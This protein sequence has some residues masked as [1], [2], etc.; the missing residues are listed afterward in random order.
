MDIINN[1]ALRECVPECQGTWIECVKEVLQIKNVPVAEFGGAVCDLFTTGRGKNRNIF[2]C[3]PAN[4]GKTFFL[5]LLHTL[6][7]TFCSPANH[8]FAWAA[9]AQAD[10]F[11]NKF[12]WH[13]ELIHWE[14]VLLLLKGE[15]VYFPTPKSISRRMCASQEI[16]QCLRQESLSLLSR[17][18][19]THLT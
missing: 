12:R 13:I 2:I 10:V 3:S 1:N 6:S 8:R 7:K 17:D 15:P 9:C 4:C 18:P 19:T 16:P 14:N 5:K 11:L